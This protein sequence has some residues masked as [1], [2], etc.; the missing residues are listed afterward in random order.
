MVLVLPQ[1]NPALLA[2]GQNFNE[3]TQNIRHNKTLLSTAI[4]QHFDA[5]FFCKDSLLSLDV[6]VANAL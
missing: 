4:T 6:T 3:D 2:Q 1:P 5:D